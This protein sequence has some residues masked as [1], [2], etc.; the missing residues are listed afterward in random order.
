MEVGDVDVEDDKANVWVLKDLC[1]LGA[2]VLWQKSAAYHRGASCYR[3]R[4]QLKENNMAVQKKKTVATGSPAEKVVSIAAAAAAKAVGA[5]MTPIM[6]RQ[7]KMLAA[8]SSRLDKIEASVSGEE[9]ETDDLELLAADLEA[10]C[11]DDKDMRAGKKKESEDDD[12]EDDDDEDDD[13]ID[14]EEID[15]GGLEEMGPKTGDD[16]EDDD[17]SARV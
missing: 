16:A 3:R 1:F 12:D 8:M 17:E 11:E 9:E 15:K 6:G 7:I 14:A 13:D 10:A 5:M 2:T 4:A